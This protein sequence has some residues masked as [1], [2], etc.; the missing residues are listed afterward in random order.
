MNKFRCSFDRTEMPILSASNHWMRLFQTASVALALGSVLV[1]R[2]VAQTAAPPAQA[3]AQAATPDRYPGVGGTY[4]AE[5]RH[6]QFY[7]VHAHCNVK[8]G[9]PKEEAAQAL[10]PSQRSFL[11]GV[12]RL[13]MEPAMLARRKEAIALVGA[14][15]EATNYTPLRWPSGKTT[16]GRWD[17]FVGVGLFRPYD[18]WQS[19]YQ[20]WV[21]PPARTV[22]EDRYSW[23][24]KI[25]V[26]IDRKRECI[27]GR[28]A[29][30]YLDI[31]LST[32]LFGVVDGEKPRERWH[33]H[34][35]G[36]TVIA[37]PLSSQHP[38]LEL[39]FFD[40]CLIGVQLETRFN[41]KEISDANIHD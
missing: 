39:G 41:P 6:R 18:W 22:D 26:S 25:S 3:Q 17:R 31:P 28:A 19:Y 20:Y 7:P 35:W 12:L 2:V 24:A 9:L 14:E 10:S 34:E 8:L 27:P 13:Y 1:P 23:Y 30:G 11:D 4:C 29:E 32:R 16:F 38:R 5:G 15:V 40:Q 37:E 33:R 36:G 21:V